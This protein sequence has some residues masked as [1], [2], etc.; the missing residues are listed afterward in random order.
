LGFTTT[1]QVS[2]EHGPNESLYQASLKEL[3]RLLMSND[4]TE[5]LEDDPTALSLKDFVETTSK[6]ILEPWQ[7]H[8][9]ERLEKLRYQRGQ[10]IL[11]HKPPQHGGSVIVSQRLPAYLLGHSPSRRIKQACYNIDHAT[12]FTKIN[13]DIMLTVKYKELFFENRKELYIDPRASADEFATRA[14]LAYRDGQASLKALGLQTGFV[15]EGADDL[16][17]DDPYAS[18]QDAASPAIR[19]RTWEFWIGN[20]KVRIDEETNVVVMFH[21]Y[22]EED[23]IGELIRSEGLKSQDG[24]WELLSYRAQW[25]GDERPEVGGPDP[26]GREIGEYLSP[27]K[28]KQPGYYRE[29]KKD[30]ITWLAQFQGKPSNPD[31]TTFEISKFKIIPRAPV[32]FVKV[33]RA[34]DIAGTLSGDYTVGVLMALGTDDLIYILDVKRFREEP[35]KRNAIILLTAQMDRYRYPDMI[36]RMPQDPAQAGIDQAISFRKLLKGFNAVIKPVGNGDK[37][38]RADPWAQYVN[39]DLV[40]LVYFKREDDDEDTNWTT[41]YIA[42][43]KK[44]PNSKK[45]DQVDASSD[46]YSEV[47]LSIDNPPGENFDT[48]GLQPDDEEIITD[49]EAIILA[50]ALLEQE[51]P[52]EYQYQERVDEY[53]YTEEKDYN[54]KTK[55]SGKFPRSTKSQ[56]EAA[57]QTTRRRFRVKRSNRDR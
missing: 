4:V 21:R 10:R 35:A 9:C 31:G 39:S 13:R 24:V 55:N 12:K 47:A 7:I 16:I 37:E 54:K 48:M 46:A 41:A 1:R 5:V 49:K 44:F 19:D 28:A 38:T 32:K 27:R 22:N 51:L 8:I 15:G 42:E 30:S 56:R 6:L 57:E 29:R 11:L 33:C 2:F 52:E 50:E 14:R 53:G 36:V 18:S 3:Q 43:H 17:I 45:K 34:W 40:R 23:Y 25:D 20:A 26:M